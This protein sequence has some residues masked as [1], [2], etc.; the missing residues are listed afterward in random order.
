MERSSWSQISADQDVWRK[1][2]IGAACFLTILPIPIA[3]G[4]IFSDLEEEKKKLKAEEPPGQMN[5]FHELGALFGRGLA[6]TFVFVLALMLFC[7]PSVVVLMSSFQAYG[8]IVS[9]H[10]L[11]VLSFVVTGVFGLIA[12]AAQFLVAL[13]FPIALAQY[14]RGMNIKPALDPMANLGY[15]FEMGAPFWFKA[16]GYWLFL[17]GSMILTLLG[18]NFWVDLLIRF[19]LAG[20]GFISLYISSKYA[21]NELQTNL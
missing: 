21:L 17:L 20:L 8:W 2:A 11:N 15:A 19:V 16:T 1:V 5:D 7:L 9:E 13:I 10:G 12:L 14:S 3:L 6:P 18:I 4:A